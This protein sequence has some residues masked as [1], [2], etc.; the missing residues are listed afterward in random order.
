MKREA[1]INFI[2]EKL[3]K[4]KETLIE[5][6]KF[7]NEVAFSTKSSPRNIR[8]MIEMLENLRRINKNRWK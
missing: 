4:S 5:K 7:V 6:S 8:E 3:N 2:I 1:K